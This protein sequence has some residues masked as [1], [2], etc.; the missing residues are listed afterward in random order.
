HA[1]LGS[2][3][4]AP[5]AERVI[6]DTE[7]P[8]TEL[9]QPFARRLREYSEGSREERDARIIELAEMVEQEAGL[10]CPRCGAFAG[11]FLRDVLTMHRKASRRKDIDKKHLRMQP[12]RNST[13]PIYCYLLIH[14]DWLRGSPGTVEGMALGGY[15]D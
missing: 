10:N 12:P 11:Q 9:S 1:E 15:A 13:K 7:F 2:A 3:R 5:A 6:L 14:P 4:M 8:F